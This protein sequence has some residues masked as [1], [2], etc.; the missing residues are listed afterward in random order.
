MRHV[1]LMAAIVLLCACTAMAQF[2]F[3]AAGPKISCEAVVESDGVHAGT[4]FRGAAQV[5]IG[6]G[7]HIN[8]HKPLDEY[9][10]ATE[11]Q[12]A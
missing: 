3:G 6:K 9:L 7:W 4:V 5:S 12:V 10:I 1:V 2:E 11:L 8:S